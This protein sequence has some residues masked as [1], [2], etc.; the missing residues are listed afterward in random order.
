MTASHSAS[1]MLVSMRSR[2][3]PALLMRMSRPPNVSMADWTRRS[4]PSQSLMSSPLAMAS[5]PMA[6]ISSTTCWAGVSVGALAVHGAAEVVDHDLG[7]LVGQ[8]QRV[9]AADAAARRP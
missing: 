2:R 5:P 4:A 3:M 7:A 8:Q 9:L 1:V 6:L